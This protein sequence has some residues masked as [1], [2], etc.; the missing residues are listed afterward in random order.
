MWVVMTS[1][2]AMDTKDEDHDDDDN[3]QVTSTA[4]TIPIVYGQ[5]IKIVIKW[6]LLA[7]TIKLSRP[8]NEIAAPL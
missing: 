2:M 3:D 8:R 4:K 5:F 1:G 6:K 7:I